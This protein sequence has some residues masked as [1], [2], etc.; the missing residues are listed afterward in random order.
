M[1]GG[2]GAGGVGV[3][4]VQKWQQCCGVVVPRGMRVGS[5]GKWRSP[6]KLWEGCGLGNGTNRGGGTSGTSGAAAQRPSWDVLLPV[7]GCVSVVVWYNV[8]NPWQNVRVG[9]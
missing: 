1:C 3:G 2:G 8:P 7:L 4:P 6:V 5:G 9:T